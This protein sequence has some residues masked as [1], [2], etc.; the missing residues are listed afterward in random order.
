MRNEEELSKNDTKKLYM[1]EECGLHYE[2]E[3]IKEECRAWCAEHKSCNLDIIKH[4]TEFK[5]NKS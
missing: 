2:S 3:A 4:S 1:C 5:G